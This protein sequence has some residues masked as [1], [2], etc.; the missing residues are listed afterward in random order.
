MSSSEILVRRLT[1]IYSLLSIEERTS[2]EV[3][4]EEVE[5]IF[6]QKE[7]LD[8]PLFILYFSLRVVCHP[9]RIRFTKLASRDQIMINT[10]QAARLI[11]S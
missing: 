4:R 1:L 3:I 9:Q 8:T 11:K 7:L 2:E 10:L 6:D 5:K